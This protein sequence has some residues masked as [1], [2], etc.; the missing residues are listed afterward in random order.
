MAGVADSAYLGISN[1]TSPNKRH[2][3]GGETLTLQML[4]QTLRGERS[5]ERAELRKEINGALKGA[6]QGAKI[7]TVITDTAEARQRLAV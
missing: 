1:S 4:Q 5:R 3:G 7:Q 6:E 2:C